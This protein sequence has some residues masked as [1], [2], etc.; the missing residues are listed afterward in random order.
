MMELWMV[1]IAAAG[2]V[3]GWTLWVAWCFC[4]PGKPPSADTLLDMQIF[5]AAPPSLT[6]PTFNKE[7]KMTKEDALRELAECQENYD[8]EIA[9]LNADE[10]LCTLLTALGYEDVVTEYNKV[11]KWFA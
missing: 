11:P 3:M 6:Y 9:H 2:M 7:M 1:L 5:G 10:V 4:W 8:I